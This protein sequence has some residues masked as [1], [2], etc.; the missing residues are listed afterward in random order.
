LK[1]KER[2]IVKSQLRSFI[3]KTKTAEW[4]NMRL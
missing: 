1:K 4:N 3:D 2:E